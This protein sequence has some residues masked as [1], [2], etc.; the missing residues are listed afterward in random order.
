MRES[1]RRIVVQFGPKWTNT[2]TQ[3]IGHR[4]TKKEER[5]VYVSSNKNFVQKKFSKK[6][7]KN[8]IKIKKK[9]KNKICN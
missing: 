7:K 6:I 5:I 3:N 2:H 9:L 1:E 8:L 4:E